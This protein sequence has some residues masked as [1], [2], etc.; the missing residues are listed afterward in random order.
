MK[1]SIYAE[2]AVPLYPVGTR[3]PT[4]DRVFRYAH[5]GNAVTEW[6]GL[7]TFMPT[8]EIHVLTVNAPVGTTVLHSLSIAAIAADKYKGGYAVCSQPWDMIG[9]IKSNTGCGAGEAFTITLEEPI[10]RQMTTATSCTLYTSEYYDVRTIVGHAEYP[11]F[12]TF[13]GVALRTFQ[14]DYYGWLQ[15]WGPCPVMGQG[16]AG[17][18][19][20]ERGMYFWMND[21]SVINQPTVGA[22]PDFALQYAGE[23]LPFTGPVGA[24]HDLLH[25]KIF[26]NLHIKP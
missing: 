10:W 3:M 8:T 11:G 9:K 14:A 16:P 18:L 24:T 25:S 15:T 7:F 1:Q 19:T 21:G 22:G 23:L 12:G 4:S 17:A 26:L 6:Y 13:V 2:S 5:L 20:G